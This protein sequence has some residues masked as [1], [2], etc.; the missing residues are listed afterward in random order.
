MS[1]ISSVN[2]LSSNNVVPLYT[3][4]PHQPGPQGTTNGGPSAANRL[5]RPTSEQL[6]YAVTF[7]AKVKQEFISRSIQ[8]MQLTSVQDD[9][10]L[11]FGH[12]IEQLYRHTHE[13][14]PKLPMYCIMLKQ[15]EM[16]RKLISIVRHPLIPFLYSINPFHRF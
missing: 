5:P 1:S 6:Q 15:E 8:N 9:Q 12:L 4:L 3:R 16:I 2:T 7:I 10:R 13:L 14:E 11:E